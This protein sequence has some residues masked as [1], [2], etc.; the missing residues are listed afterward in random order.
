MKLSAAQVQQ[1][2]GQ[3]AVR[4]V[5]ETHPAASTLEGHFGEHTFFVDAGGLLIVEPADGAEAPARSAQVITLA[6]WA[7]EERNQLVPHEPQA[8]DVTVEVGPGDGKA[9]E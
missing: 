1:V 8:T 4:A 9:A 7:D 5:P 6:A 2:E 3:I